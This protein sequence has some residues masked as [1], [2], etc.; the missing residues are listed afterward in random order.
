MEH[1]VEM[2]FWRRR[3]IGTTVDKIR[4]ANSRSQMKVQ[5]GINERIGWKR[6]RT[7]A[8]GHR[9]GEEDRGLLAPRVGCNL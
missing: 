1:A 9:K 6:P 4:S 5:E 7:I 2:D 8:A 3:L